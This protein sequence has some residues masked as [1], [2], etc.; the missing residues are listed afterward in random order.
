[1]CV[2]VSLIAVSLFSQPGDDNDDDDD[3]E[4]NLKLYVPN[5]FFL[6]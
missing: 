5:I 1:M 4:K 2:S 6:N 3:D